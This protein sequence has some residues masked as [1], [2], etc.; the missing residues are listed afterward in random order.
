MPRVG[1]VLFTALLL[2]LAWAQPINREQNEFKAS[3]EVAERG[4]Q[5]LLRLEV[6]RNNRPFAGIVHA[7]LVNRNFSSLSFGY[8]KAV[9]SGFYEMPVPEMTLGT[10]DLIVEITG[11][12]G[13]EHDNPRFVQIY[14]IGLEG[15]ALPTTL[16]LFGRLRLQPTSPTVSPSGQ[17]SSFEFST[18]LDSRPIGWGNYYVHQFVLKTDWSYFK[19]DHPKGT[20]RIAEGA[21][22]ANFIFPQSGS[23]VVFLFV[24]SGLMVDGRRLQPVLRLPGLLE[25][26]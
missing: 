5:K 12:S 24:E 17:V 19:H 16:E 7:Y 20:Q 10:Y 13:H 22:R 2:G 25:V 3:V 4:G 1:T 6:S 11:G 18:V 9:G 26:P 21:V 8:P 15:Q 23:Y 14:P